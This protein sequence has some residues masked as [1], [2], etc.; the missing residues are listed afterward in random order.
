MARKKKE[1]T[2]YTEYDMTKLYEAKVLP[3]INEI[4]KI[5]VMEKLPI[6]F[7][8]AV[9]NENGKTEYKQEGILTGST[10]V[11]LYQ[12]RFTKFLLV[13]KLNLVPATKLATF[14]ENSLGAAAMEYIND[15][16]F[17]DDGNLSVE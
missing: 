10:G 14:D 7:S 6:F 15:S 5:C 17:D 1:T 3:L 4:E 2:A 11:E 16:N 12:D 13:D 8:C 9:K